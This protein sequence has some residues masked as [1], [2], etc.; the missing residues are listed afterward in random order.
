MAQEV[1]QLSEL[2]P[3]PGPAKGDGDFPLSQ[4]MPGKRDKRDRKILDVLW[5]VSQ[6]RIYK[7]KFGISPHFSDDPQEAEKQQQRYLALGAKLSS[8]NHVLMTMPFGRHPYFNRE[9]ARAI[10]QALKGLDEDG[11]KTLDAVE[12][13]AEK[14]RVAFGRI[15]YLAVCLF[16]VALMG[17]VLA[18]YGVAS[19]PPI[20]LA[21]ACGGMGALL[22]VAISVP[23]L[24]I[25]VETSFLMHYVNGVLRIL[26]GI[27]GATICYIAIRAGAFGDL[28]PGIEVINDPAADPSLHRYAVAF[29]SVLAGF[30][31]RLIPDMLSRTAN[32][33]GN[34]AAPDK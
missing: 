32:E 14:L 17:A 2:P 5:A 24:A 19:A 22:S 6:F 8:V 7:T 1:T 4:V 30:S 10:A 21:A 13:H 15:S 16:V 9:I 29:V 33:G 26:I 23:T 11:R 18:Y 27:I 20:W 34:G 25:D 31:E 12:R 28:I 3:P